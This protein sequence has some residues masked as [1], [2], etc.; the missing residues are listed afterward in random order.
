MATNKGTTTID[1][2]AAP[3]TDYISTSVTDVTVPA[4]AF[5]EVW[6]GVGPTSDHNLTEHVVADFAVFAGTITE[7]VGFQ[8]LA[9]SRM[10]RLTGKFEINW[11]WAN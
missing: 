4:G 9:M 5:I 8:V 1:F 7:G 10:G 11:V 6:R 2:G 3:G